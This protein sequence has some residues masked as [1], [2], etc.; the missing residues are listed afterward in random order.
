LVFVVQESCDPLV[1]GDSYEEIN[2]D[3]HL[4]RCVKIK[5]PLDL[6]GPLEIHGSI[7][8]IVIRESESNIFC[9]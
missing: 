6:V 2:S 4:T 1:S 5:N 8:S 3:E 7:L 9:Q